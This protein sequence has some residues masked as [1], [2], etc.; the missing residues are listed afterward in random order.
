MPGG[1]FKPGDQVPVTGIYT[2][3]HYQHRMPHE[4]FVR[5]GEEF[6]NCRRCMARVRFTPFGATAHIEKDHDFRG[7]PAKPRARKARASSKSKSGQ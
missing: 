3:T 1:P 5:A 7:R 4:V 2:A 6:P